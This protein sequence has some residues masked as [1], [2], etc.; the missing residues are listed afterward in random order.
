MDAT[1][2]GRSNIVGFPVARML[3]DRGA[4][5]TVCH[6]KT[7]SLKAHTLNA[8]II[9]VATGRPNILTKDMV[10]EG[11]IVIDVGTNRVDGHLVGDVDFLGV[12]EKASMI[13]PVPGGVGPM[14]I[15]GLLDNTFELYLAHQKN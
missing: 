12:S 8:D 15:F 14:T 7:K 13:S 6:S 4:T 5:I 3:M 2:I 9:V 11:V 1:I 10:K